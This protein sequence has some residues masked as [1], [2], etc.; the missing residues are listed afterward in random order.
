MP[1]VLLAG[2]YASAPHH[3]RLTPRMFRRLGKLDLLASAV[4]AL[5]AIWILAQAHP[6]R[7]RSQLA[8]PPSPATLRLTLRTLAY[9]ACATALAFALA[10]PGP[11]VVISRASRSALTFACGL[12][13][14]ALLQAARCLS[15]RLV[16][17]LPPHRHQHRAANAHRY[18]SLHLH[19]LHLA[20]AHPRRRRRPRPPAHSIPTR[21]TPPASR[22]A[23]AASP[24]AQ[25][26]LPIIASAGH[27]PGPLPAT[28]HRL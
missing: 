3:G 14:C 10:T 25:L 18:P 11:S 21:S 24:S 23:S 20:L 26:L 13:L 8:Q 16:P 27:H 19:P 1:P 2:V 5:P 4:L 7:A 22:V 9:D 17:V 12:L 15:L 28:V 6:R